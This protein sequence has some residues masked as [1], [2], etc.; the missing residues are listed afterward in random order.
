MLG[1]RS[2]TP[3]TTPAIPASL[4]CW[5]SWTWIRR[6]ALK[7]IFRNLLQ[8][9]FGSFARTATW[10]RLESTSCLV[11]RDV[12]NAFG[13]ISVLKLFCIPSRPLSN[14]LELLNPQAKRGFPCCRMWPRPFQ[15]LLLIF[16]PRCH[17]SRLCAASLEIGP[18]HAIYTSPC[19]AS[20]NDH[21]LKVSNVWFF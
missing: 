8:S 5:I 21:L 2:M 14:Q 15:V 18:F 13:K 1:S 4:I 6:T 17:A 9:H 12:P 20:R 10:L 16:A 11:Q 19:H 7:K 3:A